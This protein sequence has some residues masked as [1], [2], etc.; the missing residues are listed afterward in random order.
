MHCHVCAIN[1]RIGVSPLIWFTPFSLLAFRGEC[2]R[3]ASDLADRPNHLVAGD[4]LEPRLVHSHTTVIIPFDDRVLFV[5]LLNCAELPRRLSEVAQTLD[6]ISGMQFLVG[7]RE[8]GK[9]W[10]PGAA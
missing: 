2:S 8:L 1:S 4:L 6:A 7:R 3:L 5:R 10:L 9:R